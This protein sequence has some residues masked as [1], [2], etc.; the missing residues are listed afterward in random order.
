MRAR[1][2]DF[3][4]AHPNRALQVER[5][6]DCVRLWFDEQLVA[7]RV[8][9]LD[10]NGTKQFVGI[11]LRVACR[12][13]KDPLRQRFAGGIHGAVELATHV[14][15]AV[16]LPVQVDDENRTDAGSPTI[17]GRYKRKALLPR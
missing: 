16:R 3:C 9:R 10:V 6:G 4:A 2:G 1:N 17:R 8:K 14:N 11:G 13:P 12:V 7:E 5:V 15:P